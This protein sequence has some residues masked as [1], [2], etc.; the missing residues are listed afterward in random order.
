MALWM[1]FSGT[2]TERNIVD[3]ERALWRVFQ[4]DQRDVERDNIVYLNSYVGVGFCDSTP[5]ALTRTTHRR[6]APAQFQIDAQRVVAEEDEITIYMRC[7]LDFTCDF[8]HF[9]N[10]AEGLRGILPLTKITIVVSRICSA[11]DNRGRARF[12]FH[13]LR[14]AIMNNEIADF[15]GNITQRVMFAMCLGFLYR[16]G[17]VAARRQ[18][19]AYD[20]RLVEFFRL[21]DEFN[22][23]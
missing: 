13:D 16:T 14:N 4:H 15:N 2:P 21:L 3:T 19:E 8:F 11:Y 18:G 9:L 22:N 20:P 12:T 7:V 10:Y 23:H 5:S 17:L 1:R 6:P